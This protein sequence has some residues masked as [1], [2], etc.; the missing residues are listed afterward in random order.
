M[1]WGID[2]LMAPVF[3][4]LFIILTIILKGYFAGFFGLT[5]QLR[6]Y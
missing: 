1:I 4:V 3:S 6:S 2:M 5:E